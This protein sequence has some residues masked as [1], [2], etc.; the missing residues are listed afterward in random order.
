MIYK[1]ICNNFI[2]IKKKGKKKAGTDLA[3]L[4]FFGFKFITSSFFYKYISI[5]FSSWIVMKGPDAFFYIKKIE[6]GA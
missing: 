5:L 1:L 4:M 6:T 2:I 3:T